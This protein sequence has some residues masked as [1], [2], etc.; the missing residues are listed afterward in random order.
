MDKETDELGKFG[1][2]AFY[3][4]DGFYSVFTPLDKP[5]Y[6]NKYK[7]S[8]QKELLKEKIPHNEMVKIIISNL[9]KTI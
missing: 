8:D 7:D 2:V 6:W 4:W 5:Q 3:T 1:I 9:I